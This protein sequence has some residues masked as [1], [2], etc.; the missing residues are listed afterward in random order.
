MGTGG[1]PGPR[2]DLWS[3]ADDLTTLFVG[4]CR[5]GARIDALFTQGLSREIRASIASDAR[6]QLELDD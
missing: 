5:L 1:T 3:L 2:D 4:V 6:N